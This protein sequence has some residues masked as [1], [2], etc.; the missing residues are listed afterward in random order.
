MV[1]FWRTVVIKEDIFLPT[2]PGY[3]GIPKLDAIL[4][5]CSSILSK[6]NPGFLLK[7]K[8]KKKRPSFDS[9]DTYQT[10]RIRGGQMRDN[11]CKAL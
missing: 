5:N 9:F 8:K 6:C 7:L 1:G 4:E 10:R 11:V 2:P 3:T